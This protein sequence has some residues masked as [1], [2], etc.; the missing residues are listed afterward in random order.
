[1]AKHKVLERSYIGGRIV[2]VGEEVEYT[3]PVGYNLELIED[4]V[5]VAHEPV[6][7]A[8]RI[9]PPQEK[10]DAERIAHSDAL[11]DARFPNPLE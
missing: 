7:L 8:A 6:I 4:A 3:G 11:I 5:E 1:M 2:E 9:I 10:K